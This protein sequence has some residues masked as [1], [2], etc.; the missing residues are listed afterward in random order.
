MNTGGLQTRDGLSAGPQGGRGAANVII[1]QGPGQL[2]IAASDSPGDGDVVLD[3]VSEVIVFVVKKKHRLCGAP[4]SA[5]P[6]S[7]RV[8]AS[9]PPGEWPRETVG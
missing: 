4:S 5:Q 1:H 7:A 2:P 9:E 8:A 6:P 3:A